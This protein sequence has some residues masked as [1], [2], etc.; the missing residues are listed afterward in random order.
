MQ[1]RRIMKLRLIV[2]AAL[3]AP[4]FAQSTTAPAKPAPE[5]PKITAPAVA[6]TIQSA[7]FWRLV[8]KSQQLRKMSDETDQAKAATA[9]E[10][11]VAKETQRLA[12]ICGAGFTLG[13]DQ[14]AKS[15]NYQD[16]VCTAVP[17]A[18]E[19]VKPSPAQGK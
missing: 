10:A 11:D 8:A 14:D 3:A 2:L 16:L 6:P 5:P 17:K 12:A 15:P 18:P 19:A 13:I 7:T 4:L 1:L 9:A